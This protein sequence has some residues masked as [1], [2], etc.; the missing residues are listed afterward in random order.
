MSGNSISAGDAS[1][2]VSVVVPVYN[3]EE[4]IRP[5]VK[6]IDE[7]LQDVDFE[8]ELLLVNDGSTDRTLRVAMEVQQQYG[9]QV[10]IIALQRNFGQTAA[11]QAGIEQSVGDYIVTL[12][13]DLQNDPAD[14]S[15]MVQRLIDRDLDLLVGWRKDRKD[16][17]LIRKVPSRV[18]NWLI[19]KATGVKLN[20]YGCSLKVYR[21]SIIRNIKLY[22]EMHRF[23]PAWVAIHV[24]VNRIEEVEVNHH[25]RQFGESK[26][27]ISRV[28]RVILDLISVIFFMRFRTRPSHFFGPIGMACGGIGSLM[29]LVLAF[30]KFLLGEEIG[31]RPMLIISVLLI[32]MAI[33][34]ITTGIMAEL[35]SRTYY[36]SSNR[37]TYEFKEIV[38]QKPEQSDSSAEV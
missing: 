15:R 24:P 25:A 23:I 6:A 37:S 26:Y 20:D 9:E 34:F 35:M 28:Y 1:Y 14:I 3:E 33:Q 18:A 32:V 11:M 5:L 38:Y 30:Q 31:G 16:N 17:M 7:S 10:R 19:G 13:G 29:M 4:S 8:W 12:D 27:T 22:G 36:E 21:G 2:K